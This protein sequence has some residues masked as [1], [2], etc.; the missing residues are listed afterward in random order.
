MTLAHDALTRDSLLIVGRSQ[1]RDV[2]GV[3]LNG[4]ELGRPQHF[5]LLLR[6]SQCVLLHV[7]TGRSRA[8]P[9]TTCRALPPPPGNRQDGAD[10]VPLA[11]GAAPGT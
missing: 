7:E 4:R 1:A 5:R 11:A 3:P 8:L 10:R 9:H 2:R 6:G